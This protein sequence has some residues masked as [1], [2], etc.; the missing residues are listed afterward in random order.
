V[1]TYAMTVEVDREHAEDLSA[2]L[3]EEGAGGVEVRDGEGLP[4]PGVAQPPPGRAILVAWFGDRADA[5]AVAGA[6]GGSVEEVPDQDWGESWKKG[7]GALTIGRVHVRPTWIPEPAPAGTVEVVLDPGMA[8][9]TGTH[10]TTSLCLAALSE[11][12]GVRPGAS[13]LDVGTGSGLLAI[14]AE[15]LGAARVVANDNDPIAL[16]V[17]RE[18]ADANGATLELTA[19]DVQFVEGTFDVV[20][21]NILANTLVELAPAIAARLAPC[22]IVLLSGILAS[23]EDEVR[24][25]YLALGLAPLPGVE[26]REREWSL[27][28][29]ARTAG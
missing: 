10:A 23:Q 21:A 14:A 27:L 6:R 2:E 1:P 19:A 18:N 12:L 16:K 8:F 11:L 25:A 7:L 17:A 3:L 24:R 15:K 26:R 29:L 20:V 22:G 13:V 9:G 5:E 28:A 4:M